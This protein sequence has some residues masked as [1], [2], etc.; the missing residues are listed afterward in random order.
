MR[1]SLTATVSSFVL[2]VT[3]RGATD[4]HARRA[5]V[6]T[7]RGPVTRLVE[8]GQGERLAGRGAPATGGSDPSAALATLLAVLLA[9]G[10]A[11]PHGRHLLHE[12]LHLAE[13]L[14]ELAH[15]GR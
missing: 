10:H 3:R 14:D 11:T 9:S 15:V 5:P 6:G 1:R 13:L 4:D 7:N 2:R 8:A 12:L